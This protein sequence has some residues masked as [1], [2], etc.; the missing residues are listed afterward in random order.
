MAKIRAL[1]SA[2][3]KHNVFDP[4]SFSRVNV[5]HEL[6]NGAETVHANTL[7][8]GVDGGGTRCRVRLCAPTGAK[9]GEATGGP[10]NIRFGPDQSFSAVVHATSPCP[11]QTGLSSP[12]YPRI[13]ACPALA[14]AGAPAPPRAPP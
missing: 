8:L 6:P 13:V 9:L 2:K 14:G 7:L 1:E 3:S 10:A 5:L 4:D 11:E 12:D